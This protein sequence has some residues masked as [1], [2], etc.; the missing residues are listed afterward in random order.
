[1]VPV[2]LFVSQGDK[3]EIDTRT[4]EYKNRVK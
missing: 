1:E 3:I 4:D 2:P